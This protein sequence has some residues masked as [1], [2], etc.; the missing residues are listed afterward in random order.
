[1]HIRYQFLMMSIGAEIMHICLI[2]VS[3]PEI[4]TIAVRKLLRSRMEVQSYVTLFVKILPS[5]SDNFVDKIK[6]ILII[7]SI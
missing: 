5:I 4:C 2:L 7:L 3:S 6:L 1:M